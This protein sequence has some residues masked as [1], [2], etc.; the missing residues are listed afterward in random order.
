MC[1]LKLHENDFLSEALLLASCNHIN[2]VRIYGVC[3]RNK[4]VDSLVMEYMNK[5]D[6]LNYLR[7]SNVT[8]LS[9]A[10][11]IAAEIVNGCEYLESIKMV[12]RYTNIYY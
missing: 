11:D 9:K 3:F 6:L 2:L 5:G 1:R 12:H 10:I 8:K 4:S 7:Q